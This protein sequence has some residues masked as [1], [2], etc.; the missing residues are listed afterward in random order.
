MIFVDLDGVLADFD[1]KALALFGK[2]PREIE[3]EIG[4][5]E[6]WKAISGVYDFYLTMD[7]MH[8]ADALMEGVRQYDF[9]PTILTGIPMSMPQVP[10][11]KREWCDKY[12]P[13]VEV[14]TCMSR[15]KSAYCR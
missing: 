9:S 11:H 1:K 14:I 4:S 6:F 15:N 13:G 8:D 3:D 10:G 5:K 7:K 2:K 12:F